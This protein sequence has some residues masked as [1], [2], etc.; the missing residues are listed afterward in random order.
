MSG[1]LVAAGGARVAGHFGEFL[2]GRLGPDGP[3][4][5]VTAPCAALGVRAT[6]EPGA[7]AVTGDADE[8]VAHRFFTA[9]GGLPPRRFRV[10]ADA[11]P[12][13]GAGVSTAAL[14]AMADAAGLT[15]D[16]ARAAVAAEGA[17]DPLMLDSPGDV[18][19]ASREATVVERFDPLPEFEILGGFFGPPERTRPEDDGF[20]DVADLVGM[21]RGAAARGDRAAL[22]GIATEAARRTTALR[23]PKGDPTEALAREIGALGLLRA[24]TGSARGLIFAP[25]RAPAGAADRLRAAGFADVLTFRTGG[26]R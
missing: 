11:V 1:G 7:F 17:V 16:L 21:W 14:L 20:A 22:A 18:L 23:G 2:Q 24:H 26:G 12:G 10:T 13:G 3:V 9:L 6:A 15:D 4:V 19:W 8:A 5:L 25:G